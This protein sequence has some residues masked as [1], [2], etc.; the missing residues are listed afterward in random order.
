MINGG[1]FKKC[2]TNNLNDIYTEIKA[3]RGKEKD[4]VS[5]GLNHL[6]VLDVILSV[7]V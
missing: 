3:L 1:F 7:A 5:E 6:K 4:L 2:N